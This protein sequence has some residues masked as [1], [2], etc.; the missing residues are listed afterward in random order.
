M[1][2][3]E[4]SLTSYPLRMNPYLSEKVLTKKTKKK[5]VPNIKS[6]NTLRTGN[7]GR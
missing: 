7:R 3:N 6:K 2:K 4:K 1:N 5:P